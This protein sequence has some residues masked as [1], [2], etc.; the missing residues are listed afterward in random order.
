MMKQ[1]ATEIC[2]SN[3]IHLSIKYMVH[4]LVMLT[5]S[6]Q[7]SPSWEANRF[8]ASQEISRILWNPKFIMKI[9]LN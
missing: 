7:Q 4:L 2:R 1:W 6:M 9:H 3:Q 8:A 5:Y